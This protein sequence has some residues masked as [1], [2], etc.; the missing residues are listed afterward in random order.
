MSLALH[1]PVNLHIATEL[2][3]S[4]SI[5]FPCTVSGVHHTLRPAVIWK[6]ISFGAESQAG[7][8]FVARMLTTVTSLT[9]QQRDILD[10]LTQTY[11]ATRFGQATPSLLPLPR[12]EAETLLSW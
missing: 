6:H 2:L 4:D 11:R 10:F 1:F 5:L 9:M 8:E 3:G 12:A 7:S